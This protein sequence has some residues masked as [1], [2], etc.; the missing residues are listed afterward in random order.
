MV[1]V[2][3][4]A[5]CRTTTKRTAVATD[6]PRIVVT[7]HGR[8]GTQSIVFRGRTVLTVRESF[9]TIPAGSPGPILLE[10][11]SP[12]KRWILYAIDPMGSASLAADGLVLRAVAAKGGRTRAVAGGLLYGDYRTWCSFYSLVVTAGG[13]RLAAD[14]KRLIV[15]GPPTWTNRLLV[16]AYARAFGS[17]ECA[18]DGNSV[19]VQEAPQ[20]TNGS[21]LTTRWQ[22][23]RVGL[24]G[25]STQLTAPKPGYSDESPH[26]SPDQQT[27]YFVR[28]HRGA[29]TLYA[30][31]NGKLTG[32]LLSLGRLDGYYGHRAWPYRV[33]G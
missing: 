25:K 7:R 21:S 12:D 1:Q 11:T 32:P 22:L 26:F 14:N 15:T 17:V 24:D 20:S 10:G 2:V 27:I 23:W 13:S 3:N 6:V 30:L 5:T 28:A 4:L 31:R 8:R 19:V 33:S 16:R 29:G 9:A 18:P